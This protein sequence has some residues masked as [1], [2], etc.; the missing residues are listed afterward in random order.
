VLSV[1]AFVAIW[2]FRVGVLT[3]VAFCAAAGVVD[4]LVR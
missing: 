1:V 3:V 4:Q 2:R